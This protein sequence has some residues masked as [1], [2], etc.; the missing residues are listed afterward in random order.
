MKIIIALLLI[1]LGIGIGVQ[2]Y[3]LASERNVLLA[4]L[5]ETTDKESSLE[6]ENTMLRAEIEYFSKP[7]NL[8]KEFRARF[9]YKKPGE[10][11]IIVV[12]Q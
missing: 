1:M 10:E 12:P 9:N 8:E 4:D 5:K 7:E 2:V 6:K 3:F 11:M